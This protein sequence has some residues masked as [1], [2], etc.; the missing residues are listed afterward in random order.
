MPN[1]VFNTSVTT[2]GA[3]Q[4]PVAGDSIVITQS[5]S[6]V[7]PGQNIVATTPLMTGISV[8]IA[9]LAQIGTISLYGGDNVQITGSGSLFST[10]TTAAIFTG[11]QAGASLVSNDG[12]IFAYQGRGISVTGDYDLVRNSGTIV[13]MTG[14]T[15]GN[16][17][18]LGQT[19]N[20][21][22]QIT[23]T[24]NGVLVFGNQTRIL[25]SGEITG[26]QSSGVY[27]FSANISAS[28]SLTNTGTIHSSLSAGG[29]GVELTG[30]NS[31]FSLMNSGTISGG[32]YAIRS[33]GLSADVITNTGLI[34]GAVDLGTGDDTYLG[35]GGEIQGS[36]FLGDGNDAADLR[37]SLLM[38]FAYGGLGND[39]YWV[40]RSDTYISET[41][42][43]IDSVFATCDFR[44]TP[45]VENLVLL[46]GG[47]FAGLGNSSANSIAGNMGNNRIV[48]LDGIDTLNGDAGDDRIYGGNQVDNLLGD[49]GD[50]ALFGGLGN[51]TMSGGDGDDT[52][53]GG[54][55]RDQQAGGTG[56]DQFVL[57]NL[58]HTGTTSA[59][60]DLITD[61]IQGDDRIDLSRLDA[62]RGNGVADDA[63]TFIG[64]AA[65][66][67]VAGQ[68]RAYVS[69][70]ATFVEMDVNGDGTLDGMIRL[71]GTITL[72]AGDFGL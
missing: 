10:A 32:G 64:N 65:F 17:A 33:S 44:L 41:D 66:S 72:T 71:T 5:G 51:D 57:A 23:G 20:N 69:G 50:D 3:A 11:D 2:L 40:D 35:Q 60:A 1:Y 9:G 31:V 26:Q 37:G 53:T 16:S 49:D 68:L 4:N 47:N 42:G 58:G 67:A 63:F 43:E 38:G 6:V 15:L 19:L 30:E 48:G 61:F 36:L 55:G 14:V 45:N 46:D 21:S 39:V 52:L 22:G 56:A 18:G 27:Y 24:N 70:G 28:G 29:V 7:A 62:I 59:A 12:S 8:N 34:L 25:N 13:A 54:A